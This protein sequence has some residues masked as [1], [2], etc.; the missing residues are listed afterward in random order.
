LVT[1]SFDASKI[2]KVQIL[3]RKSDQALF[4]GID[5]G[6]RTK[7]LNLVLKE[8]AKDGYF[9]KAE[10]GGNAQGYY[11]GNGALAAFRNKEQF[12]ALGLASNAGITG[13]SSNA[14]SGAPRVAFV[15]DN[16]DPMG[17]S[18]GTG[19]PRFAAAALHYANTWNGSQDHLM[20]NY[21]YSHYFTQPQTTTLSLQTQA[22]SLYEQ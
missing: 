9:G 4:T 6:T 3:D 20:T 10:L 1:R 16:S 19:I 21:Q 2:A 15:S 7:T 12:T 22:N 11:N 17:A 13:F 5:D 14:S 8:S 18:A